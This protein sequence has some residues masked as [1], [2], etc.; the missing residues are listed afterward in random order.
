MWEESVPCIC[1]GTRALVF[2]LLMKSCL[3]WDRALLQNP[4]CICLTGGKSILLFAEG[5]SAEPL[6]SWHTWDK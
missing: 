2:L 5:I 6:S 3:I 1:L 4:Q